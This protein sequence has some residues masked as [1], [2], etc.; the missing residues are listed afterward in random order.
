MGLRRKAVHGMF[1]VCMSSAVVQGIKFF[2]K[3][4]LTRILLPDDFGLVA[5]GLFVVGSFSLLQGLGINGSL[6]QRRGETDIPEAAN[7]A[8]V[9]VMACGILLCGVTF[10]SAGPL[11]LFFRNASAAA[12]VRVLSLT[13]IIT[14][15][16]VVPS[17][18]LTRGIEFRKRFVPEVSSSAV[19]ACVSI[20]LAMNGWNYWS[21]I[22]GYLASV[23]VNA[24]LM[25]RISGFRPMFSF[26]RQIARELLGYG[27]FIAGSVIVAFLMFQ[28]D[29]AVVGRILGIKELGFYSMAYTIAN[30][31]SISIGLVVSGA[32]YPVFAR[33]QHD[34]ARLKTAFLVSLKMLFVMT[35]PFSIGI[36]MMS[37][38]FV[39]LVL[40]ERWLPMVPALKIL[41][42]FALFRVMQ[43]LVGFLLHAI[44]DARLE[45][46]NAFFQMLLM[47]ALI[48]PLSLR[49]SIAGTSIA[50]TIM[51]VTGFI[52]LLILTK[53]RLGL[54]IADFVRVFQGAAVSSV[55][56]M[57][58]LLVNNRFLLVPSTVSRFVVICIAG[59]C[60]YV[61]SSF[62]ADR[63]LLTHVKELTREIAARGAV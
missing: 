55:I 58:F 10:L 50:V 36:M 53:R 13:F 4:A 26:N 23:S 49:F 33:L 15:F 12:V 16:E 52:R 48:F 62:A 56:L 39:H 37:Y 6:I 27:K 40:G 60:V 25:W 34:N 45:L 35:I 43:S 5:I 2:A 18:M 57:V 46:V 21:L 7:T 30:L 38:P 41:S 54:A 19:Y 32:L 59:V 20:A 24:V 28:C 3:I 31:P 9:I 42:V 17:A 14:S 1:W 47:A 51:L 22:Y 8:F 11:A 63:E 29:N 61:V 44:G